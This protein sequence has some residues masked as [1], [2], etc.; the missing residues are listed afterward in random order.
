MPRAQLTLAGRGTFLGVLPAHRAAPDALLH[1]IIVVKP[2]S[3]VAVHG[4]WGRREEGRE[5]TTVSSA[6]PLTPKHGR[7][8]PAPA[9]AAQGDPACTPSADSICGAARGAHPG[10]G[11]EAGKGLCWQ[12]GGDGLTQSGLPWGLLA[13]A[14]AALGLAQLLGTHQKLPQDARNGIS[15]PQGGDVHLWLLNEPWMAETTS[16]CDSRKGAGTGLGTKVHLSLVLLPRCF[17]DASGPVPGWGLSLSTS[18]PLE[19]GTGNS[20][21]GNRSEGAAW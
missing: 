15:C 16:A 9:L 10:F 4:L 3:V 6:H 17:Q 2:R 5:M 8:S 20:P 11:V 1:Q 12:R 7:T 14:A 13:A 19:G 21:V 18:L